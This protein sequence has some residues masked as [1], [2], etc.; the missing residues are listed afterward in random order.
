MQISRYIRLHDVVL[1]HCLAIVSSSG[2]DFGKVTTGQI[3]D[4]DDDVI[5]LVK[6]MIALA[7]EMELEIKPNNFIGFDADEIEK[8][9]LKK[10]SDKQWNLTKRNG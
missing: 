2:G 9:E 8:I 7:D 4:F 5:H 10:E 1:K 6:S 3:Q